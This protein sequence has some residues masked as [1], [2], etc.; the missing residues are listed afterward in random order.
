MRPLG[1]GSRVQCVHCRHTQ[2]QRDSLGREERERGLAGERK[3][4]SSKGWGCGLG[5]EML[6]QPQAGGAHM[7]TLFSTMLGRRYS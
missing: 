2:I 5:E 7:A 4:E 3:T 6:R 1:G